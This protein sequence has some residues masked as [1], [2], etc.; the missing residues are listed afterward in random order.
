LSGTC[1]VQ[2]VDNSLSASVVIPVRNRPEHIRRCLEALQNQT[3]QAKEVFVV[4]DGS[5]DET[6]QAA[7]DAGKG[8][9]LVVLR[10]PARG[11][12]AA[13]NAGAAHAS[14]G[15][16]LFTDADCT[17]RPDWIER[18]M[19]PFRSQ[20]ISGVRGAYVSSQT[21]LTARLVQSEYEDR[22]RRTA[23]L[24]SIDF[25]DTYSAAYRREVLLESGGFDVAFEGAS[26][27]DQELSFR[28]AKRGHHLVFEPSAIVSHVHPNTP[29]KYFKK[30]YRIGRFKPRVHA[31][32]PTQLLADSHSPTT[33][34]IQVLLT[35][36]S[37]WMTLL[38]PFRPR[39]RFWSILGW[40]ALFGS[41][42]P[43]ARRA[44]KHDLAAGLVAPTFVVL[45]S[46]ALM[47]GLVHG[48]LEL[49]FARLRR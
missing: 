49:L 8:L 21:A 16:I 23:K 12:G 38:I 24:G 42:V 43:F 17:P 5:T 36:G 25:I 14:A 18:M 28:I 10:L 4:D 6:A 41:G 40:L 3:I 1:F 46:L 20:T 22:Y 26:V 9:P 7:L 2:L 27:E 34:R 45:R 37:L 44:A 35:L 15:I 39:Y 33:L 31:R 13:R 29:L 19:A 47:L 32:H 48:S 11:A 30:K